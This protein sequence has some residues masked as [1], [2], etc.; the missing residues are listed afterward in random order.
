LLI[1]SAYETIV[2]KIEEKEDNEKAG[3]SKLF[4]F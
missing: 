4:C 1:R 3:V 2:T